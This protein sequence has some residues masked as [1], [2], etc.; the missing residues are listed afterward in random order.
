MSNRYHTIQDHFPT[1]ASHHPDI[2][3][4]FSLEG[5]L[6]SPCQQINE[7]LGYAS[8]EQIVFKDLLSTEYYEVAVDTFYETLHGQ[9][10]SLTI[11]VD[12]KHG[13]QIHFLATFIPIKAREGAVQ[14]VFLR[15]RDIT[16]ET[17]L[18]QPNKLHPHKLVTMNDNYKYIFNHLH[19]GIWMYESVRDAITFAS[20]GLA[21]IIQIPLLHIYEHPNYWKEMINNEHI[22]EMQKKSEYLK[23]GETIEHTYEI[24]DGE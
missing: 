20:Q 4:I 8:S 6:I 16:K 22:E 2:V 11:Q 10:K 7:Y 14:N 21:D 18:E 3:L 9:T 23:R 24:T 12:D 1:F 15:L 5:K 17:F 13:E 19:V